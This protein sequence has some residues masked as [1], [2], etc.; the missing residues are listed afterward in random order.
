L[1]LDSGGSGSPSSATGAKERRAPI[2]VPQSSD[3]AEQARQ[4]ADFLRAQTRPGRQA[5]GR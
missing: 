1:A 4:L 5:S 2:S 3:P